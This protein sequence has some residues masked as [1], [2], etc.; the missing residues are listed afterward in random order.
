MASI[1]ITDS[2][3]V[4]GSVSIDDD[5]PLAHASLKNLN[6]K[7]LPVVGDFQ[8]PID[9]FPL[10]EVEAGLGLNLPAALFG[11]D[12]ELVI[13]GG[14]S[15]SL[16]VCTHKREKLFD[17]EQFSPIVEIKEGECW[18]GFTIRFDLKESVA[19]S[20]GGISSANA[21]GFGFSVGF[22]QGI[23]LGTY[24][25]FPKAGGTLPTFK[26]GLAAVLQSYSTPATAEKL[27]ETPEGVAHTAQTT[28]S[29]KLTASYAAPLVVNP[30]ATLGMPL[31]L[32]LS[33]AP[34]VGASISGSIKL[35]GCFV[36]RSFRS[37]KTKLVF[38]VYKKRET[39][40][41]AS[42]NAAAGVGVDV[43]SA[44]VLAK[45][46]DAVVPGADLG[47]LQ[48]SDEQRD[49]LRGALKECVDHSISLALNACCT[50]SVADEAAL[51][52]ELDLS[53][54]DMT[55]T[56]AAINAALHGDWSQLGTLP[57]ATQLRNIV[58]ELHDRKH[59]LTINLLGLYN[60]TSIAD[61]LK[62]TTVLHD[63]HGQIAMVDKAAAKSLS[64]GTTPYA[65]K[66]EKLRS[67]LAHAF[68]STVAYGASKGKLGMTSFTVQQAF[69]EYHAKAE[70]GDLTQQI[71]L[72]RA[73][74][75]KLAAAWDEIL[76]SKGSFNQD[77][78]FLSVTYD[79]RTVMRLFYQD[80][81]SRTAY[82]AEAL[83]RMG[84][85]T[86]IKL[87]NPLAQN[88][89]QRRQALG[90]DDIW[91]AMAERGNTATF[92][93]IPGLSKLPQPALNAISADFLDIQWWSSA[94]LSVTPKLTAVLMA[95]EKSTTPNPLQ[96]GAFM[97]AHKALE[98]ALSNL[99]RETHSAFGDGWP[100][101]VMYALAVSGHD[102]LAPS[103]QMDIGWNGKFEHYDGGPEAAATSGG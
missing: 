43:G 73:A 29:I 32:S 42:L 41:T 3:S 103:V 65:A 93:Q 72:A 64:A 12:M 39:S 94:L 23:A 18:A 21:G 66:A 69:L 80:A 4:T 78:F 26:D 22:E 101:A 89:M 36:V 30:L 87:L 33:V 25:K 71:L 15:A 92:K 7:S 97:A 90:D 8:K 60:A 24:L 98:D 19:F 49:E 2:L 46:L 81:E 70:G 74:G 20:S 85:D 5:S 59:K 51:V 54:T 79:L 100:V 44:D 63:E 13:G 40:L 61:Y 96:D 75:L 9:Q 31:N 27:R 37:S 88:S 52:Y 10:D 68:I 82:T 6:F 95:I 91:S 14:S 16:S 99:T 1:S 17:D 84:R 76:K 56:D 48:L 53:G 86:K 47:G 83:E 57:N 11:K 35:E 55:Q 58:R 77:K 38:G 28:G 102:G 62:S 34:N 50:A 45:V 67:V